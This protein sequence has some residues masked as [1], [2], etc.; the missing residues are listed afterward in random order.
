MKVVLE[1]FE[2]AVLFADRYVVLGTVICIPYLKPIV[3]HATV[4]F[5]LCSEELRSRIRAGVHL[6][7]VSSES[8]DIRYRAVRSDGVYR[9]YDYYIYSCADKEGG[10][11]P[12]A[13]VIHAHSP[14]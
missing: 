12:K 1:C 5:D 2:A 13:Q 6:V 8:A 9:H 10:N 4:N 7:P 11:Q 14:R 3:F